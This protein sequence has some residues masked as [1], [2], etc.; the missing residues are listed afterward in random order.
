MY[1]GHRPNYIQKQVSLVRS[2]QRLMLH[3]VPIQI[4]IN[5]I[6]PS[7]ME[8]Q[9]SP[10]YTFLPQYMRQIRRLL[11]PIDPQLHV[12]VS[13]NSILSFIELTIGNAMGSVNKKTSNS[14]Y[15]IGIVNGIKSI[16][17]NTALKLPSR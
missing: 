12:A 15:V 10:L 14:R 11:A 6:V 16:A 1:K 2:Q 17:W 4:I 7:A 5:R 13:N 8:S 3:F 9:S